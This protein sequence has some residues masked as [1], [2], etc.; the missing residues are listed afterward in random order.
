MVPTT[1]WNKTGHFQK[2]HPKGQWFVI[3]LIQDLSETAGLLVSLPLGWG[4][5]GFW[6]WRPG[7]SPTQHCIPTFTPWAPQTWPMDPGH[8]RK[9]CPLLP[10]HL[11]R[12]RPLRLLTLPGV[13]PD[14]VG[15]LQRQPDHGHTVVGSYKLFFPVVVTD[16][17]DD[18]PDH[19]VRS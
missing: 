9:A 8:R 3:F 19:L 4:L 17:R 15:R 13:H 2:V 6:L 16:W 5:L 14:P 7:W 1:G 18:T 12:L 10:Q 11:H